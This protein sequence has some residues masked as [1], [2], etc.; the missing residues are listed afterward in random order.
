MVWLRIGD[1]QVEQ[2]LGGDRAARVFRGVHTLLPRHALI[3]VARE[4]DDNVAVLRE[5][6]ILAALPHPG[7]VRVF[8]TG[9]IESR[10]WFAQEIIEGLTLDAMFHALPGDDGIE[11]ATAVGMLRDVAEI[12]AYAH[13]RGVIHCA[14]LPHK[15]VLARGRGFALC[16]TDWAAAR[17]HDASTPYSGDLGPFT[18]PEVHADA[19]I[20]D[21]A[22]VFAL[23]VVA[24]R[25]L[26]G[27]MPAVQ[28]VPSEVH[29]PE[30]PR[31][32]TSLVDQMLSHDRWDRPSAAEARAEL[33]WLATALAKQSGP[34]EVVR[35]RKPRWT[36]Q[37]DLGTK[38][39]SAT[40]SGEGILPGGSP[41]RWRT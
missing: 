23:G 9:R 36:P 13:H 28:P 29:C 31:E 8:E 24:Y 14:I 33:A 2:E 26:T 39:R 15:L 3:R 27:R 41:A 17:A 34:V 5:A 30:V 12:L 4:A 20:D 11:P 16:I 35:V 22:D 38:L 19:G 7:I 18:A 21:R 37:I 1:Y 25:T 10:T 6:C 32:L 40:E